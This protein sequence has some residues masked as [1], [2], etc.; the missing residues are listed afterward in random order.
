[1]AAAHTGVHLRLL[2]PVRAWHAGTE[3]PLGS[4][5]RLAVLSVLALHANHAVS[6]EELISAVW[7][8]DPPAS[9]VGNVYTYVSALRRALEPDRGRWSAGRLLASGGGSYCLHLPEADIDVFRFDTLRAEGRDRR[10]AGDPLGELAAT[11]TAL[12]LWHGEA[13]AGVPGPYAAAQRLRLTELRLATVER[14]AALLL[15]VGRLDDA[16]AGLRRLVEEHPLRENLHGLLMTALHR[17]GRRAEALKVHRDLRELLIEQAGTEPGA[18]LRSMRDEILGEPGAEP[19]PA[20]TGGSAAEPPSDFVGRRPEFARL[21]AAVA[22]LDAGEGGSLWLEGEPGIGKSGLLTEGLRG[23][24][25]C[26]WGVG[27]ELAQRMPMSVLLEGLAGAAPDDMRDAVQRLRAAAG[28]DGDVIDQA[29]ALVREACARGPLVLVADDLQWADEATLLAWRS[30]HQLTRHL[31]LLLIAASRPAPRHR[32]LGLLRRSLVEQGA[33]LLE[34]G[35]LSERD[36]HE[37][38]RRLAPALPAASAARLVADAAGNP[39]YLRHLITASEDGGTGLTPSVIAAVGAH[40]DRF[41]EQ[42]RQIL[43]A[44]AFLGDGCTVSDLAAVTGRAAPELLHATEET[45]AAGTLVAASDRLLAFR[46]PVVRRVLHDGT[47]TALRVMLHRAFAERIA[48]TGGDP[49]RVVAQLLAGPVPIDAWAG[50]WLADHAGA[51][52]IRAPEATIAIL[53]PATAQP[54][55]D[56]AI[57]QT[58]TACLDRLLAAPPKPGTDGEEIVVIR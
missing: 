19:A 8:D 37:L 50:R 38:V 18:A 40:L 49:D 55:L 10:L 21:R 2:G 34:L 43:R 41:G 12:A 17:G 32:A 53:R 28:E 47:P 15:E 20:T 27:D 51:L 13:L 9:A 54:S 5:H 14:H 45:F 6:R 56:P 29:V 4:V 7:G 16:I 3:V 23:A 26:G 36:A 35:P 39:Y 11:E 58:L 31:P 24:A 46:H 44:I 25:G 1:M 33:E 48:E 42:T 30:L 52:S 22:D 57:R